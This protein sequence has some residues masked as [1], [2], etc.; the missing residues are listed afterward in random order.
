MGHCIA[1]HG[2]GC[3]LL[4]SAPASLLPLTREPPIASLRTS[5]KLCTDADADL[6]YSN[7]TNSNWSFTTV[8]ASQQ[9]RWDSWARLTEPLLATVPAVLVGGNHEAE[10]QPD[11]PGRPTFTAFNA[12]YPQ[13]QVRRELCEDGF[14]KFEMTGCLPCG[15]VAMAMRTPALH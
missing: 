14:K 1:P 13:P 4:R 3:Q 7:Q 9:L 5:I 15:V 12:R 8:P 6:Y 10:L 2:A 11:V